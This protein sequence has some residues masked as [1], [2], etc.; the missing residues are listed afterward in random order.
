MSYSQKRIATVLAAVTA[1]ACGTGSDGDSS[2]FDSMSGRERRSN[3]YYYEPAPNQDTWTPPP[4]DPYYD[5]YYESTQL[6]LARGHIGGRVGTVSLD[7]DANSLDGWGYPDYASITSIAQDPRA[8][9]VMTIL[10]ISGGLDNPAIQPG[11]IFS[12][13]DYD[14]SG[15]PDSVYFSV[16]GCSTT[17]DVGYWEYDAPAEEVVVEV[18]ESVDNPEMLTLKYTATFGNL[19]G[20]RTQATGRIDVLR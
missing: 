1:A 16:I 7:Q 11:A 12:N 6:T 10:D 20:S 4:E 14:Y 8:G 5:P 19:D 9:T 15:G 3:D 17:G 13:T 18:D 2:Y